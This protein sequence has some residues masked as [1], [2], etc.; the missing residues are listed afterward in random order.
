MS[1]DRTL[2]SLKPKYMDLKAHS[3]VEIYRDLALAAFPGRIE[4]IVLFGSRA[5]GDHHEES[6]WDMAVV[7]KG[8]PSF[9]DRRRLSRVGYDTMRR[10]GE[11]VQSVALGSEDWRA[12]YEL[13]RYIKKEGRPIYE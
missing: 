4:R 10:T 3:V 2:P 6:D 8:T 13:M 12:D 11:F 7:L 5:R 1:N 9:E